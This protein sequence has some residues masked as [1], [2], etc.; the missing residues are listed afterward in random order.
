LN[1]AA[2]FGKLREHELEMK[3]LNK[4]DQGERKLKGIA[5]KYAVQKE[6]S[7]DEYCSS[8]SESETLT[9][10]TRKFNKYL[11]KKEKDKN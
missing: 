7:V 4:Q 2:L 11:K 8:C 10:L 9:L 6:G 1:S 3:K 5:L